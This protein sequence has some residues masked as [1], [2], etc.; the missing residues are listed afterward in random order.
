VDGFGKRKTA[1]CWKISPWNLEE[2][3]FVGDFEEVGNPEI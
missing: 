1:Q 2:V 3:G